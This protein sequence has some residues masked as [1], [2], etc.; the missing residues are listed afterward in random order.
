MGDLERQESEYFLSKWLSAFRPKMIK[1][2][3]NLFTEFP[4]TND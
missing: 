4:T 1:L 2:K 3:M